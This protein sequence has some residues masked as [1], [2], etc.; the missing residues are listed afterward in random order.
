MS[1]GLFLLSFGLL[2]ALFVVLAVGVEESGNIAILSI[3]MVVVF[4]LA[5]FTKS[6]G[7]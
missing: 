3:V 7:V 4:V 6:M 2:I 1:E 5:L